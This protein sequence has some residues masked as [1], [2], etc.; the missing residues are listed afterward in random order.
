MNEDQPNRAARRREKRDPDRAEAS[1]LVLPKTFE[2]C[3]IP[4]CGE[5][6]RFTVEAMKGD[7]QLQDILG[8]EPALFSFEY[9]YDTPLYPV[10]LICIGDVCVKCGIPRI[11]AMDKIKGK[12][13]PP[14]RGLHLPPG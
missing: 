8:K 11:I 5:T 14:T 12:P 4:D 7:L 2:K 3:P 9:Y 6:R 1:T 13:P 10:K